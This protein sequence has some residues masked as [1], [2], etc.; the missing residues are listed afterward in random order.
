MYI[1]LSHDW[2]IIFLM[3]LL[4]VLNTCVPMCVEM[5]KQVNVCVYV[6]DKCQ[7]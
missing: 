5:E 2:F 7:S 6:E 3:N 1:L 4:T